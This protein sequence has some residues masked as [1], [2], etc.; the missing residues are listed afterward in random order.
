MKNAQAADFAG[1][2]AWRGGW[3]AAFPRRRP[4]LIS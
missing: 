3:F 1:L 4:S 2:L